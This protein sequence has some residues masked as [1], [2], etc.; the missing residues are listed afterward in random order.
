ML[1]TLPLLAVAG[2]A[3]AGRLPTE[4][5]YQG[6]N[7]GNM[8][9]DRTAKNESDTPPAPVSG[10]Y[11]TW[12]AILGEGELT[13]GDTG[14]RTWNRNHSHN[15]PQQHPQHQKHV[16][17]HAGAKARTPTEP[18]DEAR[19]AANGVHGK[20]AIPA[21]LPPPFVPSSKTGT[22][23]PPVDGRDAGPEGG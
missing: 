14:N 8:L 17:G 2:I 18:R 11:P 12:T 9:M 21:H 13:V 3:T 23:T 7:S 20:L 15:H 22:P 5:I 10:G 6:F 1:S 4:K 19:P 16:N